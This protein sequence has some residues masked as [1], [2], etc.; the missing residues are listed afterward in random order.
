M[1][2]LYERI[3]KKCG[4]T[5]LFFEYKKVEFTDFAS[6]GKKFDLEI[7]IVYCAICG[8]LKSEIIN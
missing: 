1:S 7:R 5:G 6:L 8:H 3:C 2:Y 4:N